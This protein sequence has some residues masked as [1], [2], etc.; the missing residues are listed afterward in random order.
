MIDSTVNLNLL[1]LYFFGLFFWLASWA[2]NITFIERTPM[3]F[4][5]HSCAEIAFVSFLYDVFFDGL[6][7]FMLL[8]LIILFR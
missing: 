2:S 7:L 5:K 1:R 3:S 8:L 6:N 4:F